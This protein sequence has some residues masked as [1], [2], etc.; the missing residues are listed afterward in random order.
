MVLPLTHLSEKTQKASLTNNE[1]MAIPYK[2]DL[3]INK[4]K[5]GK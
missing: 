1:N 4:E 2:D 5:Y 3:E